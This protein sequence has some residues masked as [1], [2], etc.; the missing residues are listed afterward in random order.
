MMKLCLNVPVWD[1]QE[2]FDFNIPKETKK[3]TFSNFINEYVK[4]Q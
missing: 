1:V 2:N 3:G 4:G